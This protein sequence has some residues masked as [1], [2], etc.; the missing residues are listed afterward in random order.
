MATTSRDDRSQPLLRIPR[1]QTP[2]T[3]ML[4]DGERASAML[5]V[6]PGTS[7]MRM[8]AD[9]AAFVPVSF[10]SG[11]R[12]IARD[13]IAC[14]TVHI[15]HAHVEEFEAVCER[16]KSLVRLRNGQHMK[17]ELHWIPSSENR[18]MLDHLNDQSS[19]LTMHD[20]DHVSY[21]SKRHVASAEE[22]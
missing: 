18:R 1:N 4:E 3:I 14:I 10:T 22:V 15:L 5:F 20:G 8:L 2:V 19:H 7:V 9:A 16:Q 11:V 13:S 12:L 21:I 17:G 6:A